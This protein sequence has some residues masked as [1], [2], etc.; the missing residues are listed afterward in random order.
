MSERKGC[1]GIVDHQ[2]EPPSVAAVKLTPLVQALQSSP[3][4]ACQLTPPDGVGASI[5]A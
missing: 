4:G 1:C 2:S 3:V 5:R